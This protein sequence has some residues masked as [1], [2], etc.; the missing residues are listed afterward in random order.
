MIEVM[1]E[2]SGNVVG[3]RA[4]GKLTDTEYKEV[5]I[6]KLEA[7][8]NQ[9][10]KLDVLFYMDEAFVGWDLDAAW[11]DASYGLKHRADFDKLA[12]V[13]GP[14]WVEWCIKLSGFLMKG[15]VKIFAADQL[16]RAWDWIKS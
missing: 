1:S 2:S 12:V 5:L 11:D 15:E 7:L 4:T 16:D 3:V 14:T 8:F 6:P 9:H 10:G 13:G